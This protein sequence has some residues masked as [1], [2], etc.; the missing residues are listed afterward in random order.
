MSKEYKEYQEEL[1]NIEASTYDNSSEHP[2]PEQLL[3]REALK[4][5]TPKQTKVWQWFAYDRLTH[6][7]IA[8]NLG[9]SRQAVTQMIEKIEYKVQKFCRQNRG[10]YMLLKL[11]QQ[12]DNE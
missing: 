7:E 1:E 4:T 2:T 5:L 6:K 3:V 8:L 10:A 12:I 9:I 11:E